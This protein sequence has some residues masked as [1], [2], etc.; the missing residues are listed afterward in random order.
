MRRARGCARGWAKV[1]TRFLVTRLTDPDGFIGI[2]GAFRFAA[3]GMSERML[4][5]QEVQAGKYVTID[6]APRGFAPAK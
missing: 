4:E 3:N 6:P 2:D 1:G 5:V